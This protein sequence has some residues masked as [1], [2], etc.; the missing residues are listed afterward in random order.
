LGTKKA[1]DILKPD[2]TNGLMHEVKD[3][4]DTL[5]ASTSLNPKG[6]HGLHREVFT[7]PCLCLVWKF[8][9]IIPSLFNNNVDTRHPQVSRK[10]KPH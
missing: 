6:L 3:N 5:R 10:H 2:Q 9:E 7:L 8:T 1:M 4:C